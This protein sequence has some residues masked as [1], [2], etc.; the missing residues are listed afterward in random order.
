MRGRRC[1][2]EGAIHSSLMQCVNVC[3]QR[4]LN[5]DIRSQLST[6]MKA[7]KALLSLY[8]LALK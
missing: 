2:C 3:I 6:L 8:R 5:R 7:G 1:T 4:K